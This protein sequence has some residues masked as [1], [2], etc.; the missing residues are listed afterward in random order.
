[1]GPSTCPPTMLPS[2]EM[3]P[4]PLVGAKGTNGMTWKDPCPRAGAARSAAARMAAGAYVMLRAPVGAPGW[5]RGGRARGR[6]A[7]LESYVPGHRAVANISRNI[8][9]IFRERGRRMQRPPGRDVRSHYAFTMTVR[10]QTKE[11]EDTRAAVGE[12]QRAWAGLLASLPAARGLRRA[13]GLGEVL[14]LNPKLAWQVWRVVHAEDPVEVVK[15]LPG[16]PGVRI[17]LEAAAEKGASG[18]AVRAV[19]RAMGRFGEVVRTH[20]GDRATL[21]VMLGGSGDAAE[22]AAEEKRR[23]LFQALSAVWGVRA[24][25]QLTLS[26]LHPGSE[27]DV[28]DAASAK[29]LVDL[30]RLRTDV[31]WILA[32]VGCQGEDTSDVRRYREA[33]EGYGPEGVP[34]IAKFCSRPMP[35]VKAIRVSP[36]LADLELQPGPV[37]E[38]GAVTVVSGSVFRNL[39]RRAS[40][41]Q[42]RGT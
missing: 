40:A 1:M 41:Q 29:V 27:A 37:G 3:R 16:G 14:G 38:T 36:T 6:A 39:Q 28:V 10:T 2:A 23:A 34:L 20:A 18:R 13:R 22:Q 26:I 35:K 7:L 24:R 5:G 31:S 33:I 21:G 32:R 19:E 11:T 30:R 8:F 4:L 17:V 15:H 25:A 9:G 12:V 42:P